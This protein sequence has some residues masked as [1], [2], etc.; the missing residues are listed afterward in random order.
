MN[1]IQVMLEADP[2]AIAMRVLGRKRDSW[3]GTA[4]ELMKLLAEVGYQ[5]AESSSALSGSL[6]KSAPHLRKVGV[7]VRF[8]N[9]KAK[10]CTIHV[11]WSSSASSASRDDGE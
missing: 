3:Q 1:A 9:R 11:T 5:E 2:L 6:R 7:D 10:T 8:L 4:T